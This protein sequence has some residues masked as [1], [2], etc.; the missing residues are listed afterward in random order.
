M[1]TAEVV[2]ILECHQLL[3]DAAS[4]HAAPMTQVCG[5]GLGG[6][7]PSVSGVRCGV[8]SIGAGMSEV[9]LADRLDRSLSG[10]S[11]QILTD[12][13]LHYNSITTPCITTTSVSLPRL[14]MSIVIQ[15][16]LV[17][18]LLLLLLP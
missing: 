5:C 16:I 10:D 12:Q 18:I 7:P 8:G 11:G 17:K 1:S 9:F 2:T 4:H 14:G 15:N 13:C 6:M 3:D